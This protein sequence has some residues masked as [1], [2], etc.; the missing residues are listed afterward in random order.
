M[1]M[2]NAD[3]RNILFV[4]H[5]VPYP[6]DKG[7][8]I[9]TF[10]LLRFLSRR[11][12]VYL[13][14]LADEPVAEQSLTTLQSLCSRVAIVAA[15]RCRRWL[16]TLGALAIGRTATEGAFRSPALMRQVHDWTREVRFH[17]AV[18]SSSGVALCVNTP[19]L[20]SIPAIVDLMDVDSQKWFDYAAASSA[21]RSWLYRLEGRRLR[22]LE[23]SIASTASAVTLVSE[24]EADLFRSFAPSDNVHSVSNGVDLHYFQP[25]AESKASGC[26]FTGA[27]DY[28]P[29]VDALTWFCSE[30]WP[31]VHQRHPQCKLGV[32]GR[33]PTSA[34]R[35]LSEVPG[36]QIVGQV[37]DIRPYLADAAVAVAPLRIARGLQNKVLE[38]MAMAKPVVASP[39]ALGGFDRKRGFPALAARS[40]PEWV[41]TLDQLLRDDAG[42]SELGCTGRRY[43]E[44]HYDWDKCL[45]PFASLL[46]LTKDA[47]Q[48]TSTPRRDLMT[49]G[50][51]CR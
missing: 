43:V 23:Q 49:L 34:V 47:A 45:V 7:D 32:I 46:G 28:R 14:C 50:S 36:V 39:Q 33:Q 3:R 1:D 38:A 35:R 24:A 27:L 26:V 10:N 44:M 5:R 17:G 42:S 30:I 15:G 9:R 25:V 51:G 12:R 2:A 40:A 31:Q 41:A 8:R 6:P 16:R 13:A 4:A 20:N 21:P 11:A 29:N 19:A 22:R 18:A 48:V 37:P